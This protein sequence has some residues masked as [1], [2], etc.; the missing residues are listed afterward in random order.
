ML[1]NMLKKIG[2]QTVFKMLG[3]TCCFVTLLI[4]YYSSLLSWCE[5]VIYMSNQAQSAITCSKLTLETLEHISYL[6]C[7]LL[8]LSK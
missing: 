8:T 2:P 7:L 3:K 6:V 5:L 4:C 1:A